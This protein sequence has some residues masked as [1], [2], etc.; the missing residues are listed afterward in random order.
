[1]DAPPTR[2]SS[3]AN[4][5]F[6]PSSAR[7]TPRPGLKADQEVTVSCAEGET[8]H[9]YDG[10]LAFEENDVDVEGLPRTR[11]KVMLNLAAPAGSFRWWRLPAD[12]VGLARM[13]FMVTHYVRIHPM[14]LLHPER[15]DAEDR[16]VVDEL[17]DGYTDRRAYFTDNVAHGVARIAASRWPD[18]V[19]VRASDFKTNEYARLLGGRP[20]EPE[21]A[22]P[23]IGWRGASRY[24]GPGYREAFALECQGAVPAPGTMEFHHGGQDAFGHQRFG[25]IGPRLAAEI[26]HWLGKEAR[27]VVLGHVQRGGTPTALDRV[28]AT[29]FGWHAVE[30]LHEGTFG[31]LTALRRTRIQLVP[32][33]E[34]VGRLRTVPPAQWVEARAVL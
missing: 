27:P 2:P 22:N 14:A 26:E 29:R 31:H 10:R 30:A 17:T 34:T 24:Y 32:L 25:G 13:E 19:V 9:V 15:L 7:A 18:P 6:P 16:R 4:S 21:E 8:G 5:A 33:A 1:M 12:G 20:F 23:M 11:T 3:A 28:L